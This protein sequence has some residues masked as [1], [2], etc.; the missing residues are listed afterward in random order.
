MI[1]LTAG[2]RASIL[3]FACAYFF[4][5]LIAFLFFENPLVSLSVWLFI[6][7][8]CVSM[9]LLAGRYALLNPVFMFC[10]LQLTLFSLNWLPFLFS[11]TLINDTY[12]TVGL[13]SNRV[14]RAI[15]VLNLLTCLW[16]VFALIGNFL[17]KFK[18]TWRAADIGFNFRNIALVI[19]AISILSFF[20]LIGKAG[21]F[22]ELMIQREITREDR[23]AASI[24]RHWFAFAQMG[25]L[26]VALWA[27]SDARLFKSWYFLPIFATVLVIGF[28]VSGNRTSIVMSCVLIY[29]AWAFGSKKLVS[30]AIIAMAVCLFIALGVASVVREVGFSNLQSSDYDAGERNQGFL[31]KLLQIRTE[32]AIK[33]NASLGVLMGL[34]QSMPF[35]FG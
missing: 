23:L 14:G 24:G 22:F 6:A 11:D 16:L 21:S 30:P 13:D 25:I 19:I 15:I 8:L 28:I 17:L 3:S 32:R 35:L 9:V 27:F 2:R 31:E 33:G 4:G 1:E 12:G 18:V 29:G 10:L 5:A 26:G 34:D 20:V 7:T